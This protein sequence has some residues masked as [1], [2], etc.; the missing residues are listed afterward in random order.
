MCRDIL[1]QK[2]ETC[3]V[4]RLRKELLE[5]GESLRTIVFLAIVKCAFLFS[6]CL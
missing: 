1:Y 3:D 2:L 4:L 5:E 6:F